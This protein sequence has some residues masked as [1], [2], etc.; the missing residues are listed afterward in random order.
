VWSFTTSIWP[1]STEDKDI[2][3]ARG[4]KV[5]VGKHLFFCLFLP[6]YNHLQCFPSDIA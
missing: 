2:G 3:I 6:L 5:V 4:E 1:D